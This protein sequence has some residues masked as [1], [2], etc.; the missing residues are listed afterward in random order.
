MVGFKTGDNNNHVWYFNR[1][2]VC[3]F[4]KTDFADVP[5]Y[6]FE[7]QLAIT[8]ERV[9]TLAAA[10]HTAQERDE[11]FSRLLNV[12]RIEDPLREEL[13]VVAL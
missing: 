1:L 8:P 12:L 2:G 7:V 3:T 4:S 13:Q 11:N 5:E 6:L 9:E 10:Y